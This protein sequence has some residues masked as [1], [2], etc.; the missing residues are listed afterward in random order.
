M[1][2]MNNRK[3]RGPRKIDWLWQQWPQATCNPQMTKHLTSPPQTPSPPLWWLARPP[4]Q[5]KMH[6]AKP[7]IDHDIK[8]PSPRAKMINT[9]MWPQWWEDMLVVEHQAMLQDWTDC[10]LGKHSDIDLNELSSHAIAK[11][12][13][14]L[15]PA[16]EP[17][18]GHIK[19]RILVFK[20]DFMKWY[21]SR[22][23]S[24]TT[25]LLLLDT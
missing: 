8:H 6:H 15:P 12:P 21:S 9:K 16:I 25:H 14:P 1:M 19:A 11:M 18:I 5:T 4:G 2:M 13:L 7:Q 3:R 23:T 24:F 22:N 10:F 20:V 17:L